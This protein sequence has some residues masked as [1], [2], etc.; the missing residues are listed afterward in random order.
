[1]FPCGNGSINTEKL[2]V[3]SN[4]DKI[5][6][7]L[8]DEKNL[9]TLRELFVTVIEKIHVFNLTSSINVLIINF[10][11][12]TNEYFLYSYRLMKQRIKI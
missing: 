12:G 11:D 2:N 8:M 7:K 3:S 6:T 1:M 10:V 5:L 4:A 9:T